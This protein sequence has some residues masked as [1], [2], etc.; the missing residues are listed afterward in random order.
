MTGID[1]L[2]AIACLSALV[3]AQMIALLVLWRCRGIVG[4][5]EVAERL[6]SLRSEVAN[7]N[8]ELRAELALTEGRLRQDVIEHLKNSEETI[9]GVRDSVDSRFFGMANRDRQNWE[10]LT[11]AFHDQA[12]EHRE[13]LEAIRQM[14]NEKCDYVISYLESDRSALDTVVHPRAM[15]LSNSTGRTNSDRPLCSS[16]AIITNAGW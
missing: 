14:V 11:R 6:V 7:R 3:S 1:T 9:Q 10:A 16:R 15:T 4:A 8:H 13:Q 12:R 5:N 2:T